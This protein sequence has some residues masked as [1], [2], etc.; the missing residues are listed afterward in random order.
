MIWSSGTALCGVGPTV[1]K[2]SR[3]WV[4]STGVITNTAPARGWVPPTGVIVTNG[5]MCSVTRT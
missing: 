1:P 4:S 3:W 5:V 2:N